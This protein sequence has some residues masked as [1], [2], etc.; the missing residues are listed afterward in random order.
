MRTL[1]ISLFQLAS[2]VATSSGDQ[3]V[4]GEQLDTC[5]RGLE[6]SCG[7]ARTIVDNDEESSLVQNVVRRHGAV[8]AQQQHREEQH[9]PDLTMAEEASSMVK[10]SFP[11][12]GGFTVPGLD[13]LKKITEQV[14]GPSRM[15]L[16]RCSRHLAKR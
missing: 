8:L 4:S 7:Q 13:G 2:F 15:Y 11:D 14:A 3:A 6:D 1:I 12:L 16:H 10:S 5:K 9:F